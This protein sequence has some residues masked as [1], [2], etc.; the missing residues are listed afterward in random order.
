MTVGE[1][2]IATVARQLD[3]PAGRVRPEASLVDD[4]GADE[5][6]R[7]EIVLALEEEFGIDINDDAIESFVIVGDVVRF[8][9]RRLGA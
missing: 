8:V 2:V 7:I 9:E 6:S 1:R 4:L 3:L 5:L